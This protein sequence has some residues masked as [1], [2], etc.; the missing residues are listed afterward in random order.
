MGL[1][2]IFTK[3]LGAASSN[4]IAASQ[5]ASAGVALTLNGSATNYLS[6][7]TTA[8][9]AVGKVVLP[10]S[11]VTGLVPG[12]LVTD[13]TAVTLVSGTAI[14]GVGTSGVSIWPPV[15]GVGVGS[16][17]T[18]VFPGTAIIDTATA[19]N[20]AIGRRV[21]IAYTGTDTSFAIVGT[22]STGNIITDT[23]VGS[24]GSA[25]SNLDFVTVTSITPVGGGLTGVTV[26]T[27]GTGAS[28]WVTWNWRGYSPMNL[29]MAI[30]LVSGAVNFTVQHTYDDPN[31]LRAGSLYPLPFNDPV[32][33][34]ASATVESSILTPIVASRVLI[35]SGTGEI[36]TRFEQAGAG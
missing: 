27:N 4:N 31:S 12:Q 18:I 3:Q 24:G 29:G 34:G 2:V 1:R 11:S 5:S 16:G 9:V 32:I 25:V 19:N 10:L 6:T 26:G 15:G 7:T 23:A 21:V 17:D 28:P 20:I 22:N 14:Q 13:A 33:N 30:E 36:R 8:A 35:N